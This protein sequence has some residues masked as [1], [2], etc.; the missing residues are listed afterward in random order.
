MEDAVTWRVVENSLDFM[1][2][3]VDEVASGND[4]RLK[5]AVLHLFAGIETLVKSRLAREHWALIS[6]KVERAKRAEYS[7]GEMRS[8]GA[9][10]ALERLQNI[11]GL[12]I[13]PG[14]IAAVEAVEKLRNRTAHFALVGETPDGIRAAIGRGLHFSLTFLGDHVAPDA[15]GR[16][17]TAIQE[18]IEEVA[19]A[20]GEIDE[21][22]RTRMGELQERLA[23][24]SPAVVCARC[25]QTAMLLPEGSSA[26]CLFCLY[27]PDG[28]AAAT[29]YV[30]DVLGESQYRIIKHGGEWP[31]YHCL[32]CS[33]EALVEGIQAPRQRDA[34]WGC[35]ACGFSG[36][37]A[38]LDRC[39]S[40]GGLIE[41]A[42]DGFS[43]CTDC[44]SYKLSKD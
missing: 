33:E 23:R 36:M 15:P 41:T 39:S 26:R 13:D 20:L 34:Y 18:F 42:D 44:V 29:E 5:Y 8:V 37:S 38:M 21:L 19:P 7:A 1:R 17:R 16:E 28:E 35:F 27:A 3:A 4:D 10:Q 11:V 30:S 32:Q 2:S 6:E 43:M 24:D 40:C 14:E 9:K 22:V 25:L 31:V 12:A